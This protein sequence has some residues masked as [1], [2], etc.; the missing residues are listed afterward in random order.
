MQ[1]SAQLNVK[2]IDIDRFF[3]DHVD[4]IYAPV[5]IGSGQST[6]FDGIYGNSRLE[7]TFHLYCTDYFFG[8]SCSTYCH[9][10]NI[11][12]VG[13]FDCGVNGER[14]CLSGWQDPGN[15][16]LTRKLCKPTVFA[17]TTALYLY[18]VCSCM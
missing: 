5:N 16:C 1:G 13:H 6:T 17:L 2:V 15:H 12:D 4:D 10:L 11:A 14:L 7:M 9:P 8:V 18:H 3:D